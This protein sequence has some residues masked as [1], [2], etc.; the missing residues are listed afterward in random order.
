MSVLTDSR[1]RL[2]R[3]MLADAQAVTDLINAADAHDYGD[4]DLTIEDV[5]EQFAGVDLATDA[6]LLERRTDDAAVGVAFVESRAG[7]KLIAFLYVHPAERGQGIGRELALLVEERGRALVAD[8]PEGARVTLNGWIKG[9]SEPELCWAR[10]LGFRRERSFLRMQIRMTEA[11]PSP[12]WPAGFELRT[13]RPG[14]DERIVFDAVEEAFSDH[15]GH[16]PGRLEEWL[17]R[18]ERADFDPTLWFLAFD[19][20]Q[21]AATSLC[22][23]M[24]DARGWVSSLAVRR[25]WRHRGLARAILL[26]SLGE[27]WRR[28]RPTVALGVDAQSLT[29]ATRLYESVGMSVRERHDQVTKLLRDGTDLQVRSLD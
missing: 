4:T 26:A 1:F 14:S 25:P 15:W 18:T 3:P 12:S 21:L 24:P 28:G 11:P 29:G 8:A 27:F 6:W 22:E 10:R 17:R 7:V 16:V 20:E 5:R 13:F 23:T 19:G 9:D 2:R